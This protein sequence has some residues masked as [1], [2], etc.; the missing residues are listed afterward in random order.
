MSNLVKEVK[1]ET[2]ADFLTVIE[3]ITFCCIIQEVVADMAIERNTEC[4]SQD[5]WNRSNRDAILLAIIDDL[6]RLHQSIIQ[7]LVF[8]KLFGIIYEPCHITI[9]G[10]IKARYN[11]LSKFEL[12]VR[13]PA[14]IVEINLDSR[15]CRKVVIL[16]HIFMN[17]REDLTIYSVCKILFFEEWNDLTTVLLVF[18]KV[19]KYDVF[20][21]HSSSIS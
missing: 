14:D 18:D 11:F 6:N 16:S 3:L 20:N 21:S 2:D 17:N 15:F 9:F 10:L 5:L 1:V 7:C 4:V 13:Q 12:I 8:T 19:S